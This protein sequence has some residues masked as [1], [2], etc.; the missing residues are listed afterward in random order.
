MFRQRFSSVAVAVFALTIPMGCGS[1]PALQN[2]ILGT[3]YF[4]GEPLRGG[5]V[6]FIPDVEQGGS[7]SL[8]VGKID[9]SGNYSINSSA[10]Y[11]ISEGWHRVTVC[12]E[13]RQDAPSRYVSLFRDVPNRYRN[14]ELS[15]LKCE[16]QL[17][18]NRIDIH[19]EDY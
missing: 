15:G 10:E 17:G 13:P 5:M 1:K 4:H 3:V 16:L 12:G 11:P 2:R 7:G 14:P 6:V 19:L 8:V 9:P 18:S